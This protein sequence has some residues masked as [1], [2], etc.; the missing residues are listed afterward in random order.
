MF[1]FYLKKDKTYKH[2]EQYTKKH[3]DLCSQGCYHYYS[4]DLVLQ[5]RSS[6]REKC[7]WDTEYCMQLLLI[8]VKVV[9]FS[10]S[11]LLTLRRNECPKK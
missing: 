5:A 10:L 6:I 1:F 4:V 11:V 9:S 7:L 3:F 2:C 8:Q